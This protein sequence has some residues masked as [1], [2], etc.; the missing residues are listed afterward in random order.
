[1]QGGVA[2]NGAEAPSLAAGPTFAQQGVGIGRTQQQQ[3]GGQ[4]F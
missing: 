1:M 4:S 2:V 3:Q